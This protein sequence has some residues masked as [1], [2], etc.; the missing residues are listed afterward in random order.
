[1]KALE[2]QLLQTGQLCVDPPGHEI[3]NERPHGVAEEKRPLVWM[4][5]IKG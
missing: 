2:G 1:M 4:F 3:E 5:L